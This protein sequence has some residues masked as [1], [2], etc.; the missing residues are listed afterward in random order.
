MPR[1]RSVR[2]LERRETPRRSVLYP[3]YLLFM[4]RRFRCRLVEIGTSGICLTGAPVLKPG[5]PVMVETMLL[6]RR[7]GVVAH[8]TGNRLGVAL[9]GPPIKL[10]SDEKA[11]SVDEPEQGNSDHAV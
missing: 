11:R 9:F 7:A 8:R 3:A 1:K 6:G 5:T 2:L 4:R 10:E